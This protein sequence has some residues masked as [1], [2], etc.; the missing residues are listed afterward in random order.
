MY[1]ISYIANTIPPNLSLPKALLYAPSLLGLDDWA[2]WITF[3][4]VPSSLWQ[5]R[6]ILSS[7][8]QTN[9]NEG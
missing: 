4:P 2:P 9:S 7:W 5:I 8:G 6:H 1:L 3:Q